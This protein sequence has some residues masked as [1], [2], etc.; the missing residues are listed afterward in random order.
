MPEDKK[1]VNNKKN[2]IFA[3]LFNNTDLWHLNKNQWP[4]SNAFK[5]Q[6]G[7]INEQSGEKPQGMGLMGKWR[8]C[9][10]TIQV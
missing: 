3:F 8:I 1:Q 6:V 9:L 10:S 4:D 7:S 2:S 5:S